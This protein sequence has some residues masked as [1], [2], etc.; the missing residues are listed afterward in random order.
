M[1]ILG[2]GAHTFILG[3]HVSVGVGDSTVGQ[4]VGS[5]YSNCAAS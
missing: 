3:E 1:Q 2:L 4:G 5:S